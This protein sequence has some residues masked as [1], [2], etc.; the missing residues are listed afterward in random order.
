MDLMDHDSFE[1]MRDD[2]RVR[3]ERHRRAAELGSG[4]CLTA[5]A[6]GDRRD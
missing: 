3:A 4:L 6:G 5:R 2:F 1:T